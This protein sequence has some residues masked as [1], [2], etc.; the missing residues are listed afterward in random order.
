MK[1]TSIILT[2]LVLC[3]SVSYAQE[4]KN[5]FSIDAQLR[6]RAEYRNGVL[7][8]RYEGDLHSAF[9]NSRARFSLGYK[10]EHLQMKLS[11]QH[12]GVWGQDP[13]IDKNGRFIFN[14]AWAKLDFGKGV[15]AQVGR[16]SL[17]YDDERLLGSLDWNVAGRYHDALKLGYESKLHKLHLVLAFNQNDEKTI[18][19]TFYNPAKAQ[20]YKTMQTLWYNGKWADNF[21]ASLLFMNVGYE[22]GHQIIDKETNKVI[23]EKGETNYMPTAGTYLTY[24]PGNWTL[25]GSFYYQ[26]GKRK[27]GESVKKVSAYMFGV[28]AAYKINRQW[29]VGILTDYLSGD[30]ES[31]K[32]STFDPLYGTHHKFYGG[33][34]Y[35]YASAYNKG[36]WDKQ[37]SVD[38]KPDSRWALSLN[39]HHFSTTY[40]VRAEGDEGRSLG[41]EID[42]QVDYVLMKDVKLTAGYSTMLGTKYMDVVKGGSHKAWQDWGWLSLNINPRIFFAKW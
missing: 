6:G 18:G 17:V 33:M 28:K 10:R 8:P 25:N 2:G 19:G 16:Q 7:S 39:Y 27:V 35:F 34:D 21:N 5:E 15:F 37:L 29:S 20:P 26:F 3:S 22:T 42:F 14:E 13:Q 38:F 11:A 1:L 32:A 41:S 12:V 31:S 36:L 23:E 9:I 24:T 40:D 4:E 30:P